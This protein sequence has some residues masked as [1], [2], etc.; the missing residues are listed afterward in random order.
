ML[1]KG[2]TT[3]RFMHTCKSAWQ[4][5]DLLAPKEWLN[6]LLIQQQLVDLGRSLPRPETAAGKTLQDQPKQPHNTSIS[7]RGYTHRIPISKRGLRI[8][9]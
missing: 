8:S 1:S 7:E 2:A 9:Q 3:A 4:I 5:V 6:A